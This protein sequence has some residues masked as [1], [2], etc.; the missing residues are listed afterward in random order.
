MQWLLILKPFVVYYIE[1][2]VISIINTSLISIHYFSWNLAETTL[3]ANRR[4]ETVLSKGDSRIYHKFRMRR[5]GLE[6]SQI[7]QV[8]VSSDYAATAL[9]VLL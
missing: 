1:T 8:Y 7:L 5:S 3:I 2:I 6:S 9:I 4:N